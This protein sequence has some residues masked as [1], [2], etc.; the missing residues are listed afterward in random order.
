VTGKKTNLD[1]KVLALIHKL[2]VATRADKERHKTTRFDGENDT[3]T[4]TVCSLKLR[5]DSL[6]FSGSLLAVP[7]LQ[8]PYRSFFGGKVTCTMAD[9]EFMPNGNNSK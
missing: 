9:S 7:A 5:D 2:F 3:A 4:D 1:A 6:A 8:F